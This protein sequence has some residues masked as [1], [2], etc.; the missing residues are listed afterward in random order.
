VER[1]GEEPRP[2]ELAERTGELATTV[3]TGST[4][5]AASSSCP[6]G[7]AAG[8]G[9][10]ASEAGDA[11]VERRRGANCRLAVRR[12]DA[13]F[14]VFTLLGDSTCRS[15]GGGGSGD[16]SLLRFARGS[17]LVVTEAEQVPLLLLLAA[18]VVGIVGLGDNSGG[19]GS[20]CLAR[21]VRTIV[22][23]CECCSLANIQ[24]RT[25]GPVKIG[26]LI[27]C[28]SELITMVGRWPDASGLLSVAMQ[29]SSRRDPCGA[30][31]GAACGAILWR[32]L[33]LRKI[34]IYTPDTVTTRYE[35]SH[36]YIQMTADLYHHM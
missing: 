31:C 27:M 11:R 12:C 26:E 2:R 18:A 16:A 5:D 9:V 3:W 34:H 25:V 21:L 13:A 29:R 32:S 20:A 24:K 30:A 1:R 8:S 14:F 19:E 15:G 35:I 22:S 10:A 33:T 23:G 6:S 17:F 7:A 28:D 36:G 4:G